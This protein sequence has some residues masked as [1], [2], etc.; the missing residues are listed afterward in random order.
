MP[1]QPCTHAWL[2]R[3][4]TY[5]LRQ[6]L[7][8]RTQRTAPGGWPRVQCAAAAA[9]A[10]GMQREAFQHREMLQEASEP[11][12]AVLVGGQVGQQ[13]DELLRAVAVQARG[14]LVQEDGARVRHQ[15]CASMRPRATEAP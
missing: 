4:G 11:H 8:V 2:Q 10:G 13:R 9:F 3:G 12:R 6:H 14:G 1:S 7:S 15:P 5:P